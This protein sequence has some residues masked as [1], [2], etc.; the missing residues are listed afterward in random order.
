MATD[1]C[2]C[3]ISCHGTGEYWVDDYKG[4]EDCPCACHDD[5]DLELPGEVDEECY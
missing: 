2:R 1:T 4:Y 5:G 3:H